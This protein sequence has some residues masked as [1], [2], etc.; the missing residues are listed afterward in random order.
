VGFKVRSIRVPRWGMITAG[1][2]L[3]VFGVARNL[4]GPLS[5]LDSI[6]S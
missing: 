1:I 6:A 3:V 4:P 2:V 5:F